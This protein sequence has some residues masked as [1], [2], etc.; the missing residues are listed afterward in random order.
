MLNPRPA[1]RLGLPSLPGDGFDLGVEARVAQRL[2]LIERQP[3]VINGFAV[4]LRPEK[5]TIPGLP[6]LLV[7]PDRQIE[8]VRREM[9][10]G[11]AKRVVAVAAPAVVCRVIHHRGAHGIELDVALAAEQIGFGLDQRGLVA[12]V[13]QGSTA[14][15]GGVDV[16]HVAPA[17]GDDEPRD[18]FGV[19]GRD[20][21][22]DVVC[23]QG[24]GVK[25]AP[26]FLQGFAQP[27]EIAW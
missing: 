27:V 22:M 17:Q 3:N 8:R 15:V 9:R 16:L 6:F 25:R 26:L 1:A 23:H 12:A 13:P 19:L 5:T 24:V 18:G 21:Q 2:V 10:V 11:L 20:K 14:T 4:Q 7:P